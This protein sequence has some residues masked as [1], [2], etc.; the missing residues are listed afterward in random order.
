[1]RR[2]WAT[3][4]LVLFSFSLIG[5]AVFAEASSQLPQCCSRLGK[6]HCLMGSGVG[7]HESSS[8]DIRNIGGKCPYYPFGKAVPAHG[9]TPLLSVAQ[10]IFVHVVGHAAVQDQTESRYCITF[11]RSHQKRGPPLFFS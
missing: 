7:Q 9:K 1:M 10:T 3:L 11:D 2:T 5:P 6:H 8:S 4:L